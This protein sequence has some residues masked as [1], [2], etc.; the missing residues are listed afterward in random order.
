MGMWLSIFLPCLGAGFGAGL[1]VGLTLA[2]YW[3]RKG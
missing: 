1:F 3:R 2:R